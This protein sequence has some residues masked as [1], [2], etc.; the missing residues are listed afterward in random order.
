MKIS[1]E[2]KELI[3]RGLQ[4]QKNYIETHDVLLSA[5]DARNMEKTGI[6]RTLGSDQYLRLVTLEELIKKIG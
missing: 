1:K 5:Q 4:M 6:I 3:V 2:E